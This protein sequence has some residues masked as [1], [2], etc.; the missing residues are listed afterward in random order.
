MS[1]NSKYTN[2]T[3]LDNIKSKLEVNIYDNEKMIKSKNDEISI[4]YV[5]R[6]DIFSI[7]WRCYGP[8]RGILDY[9]GTLIFCI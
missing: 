5:P 1:N 9:W 7:I 6:N 8:N 2:K 3:K 4:I